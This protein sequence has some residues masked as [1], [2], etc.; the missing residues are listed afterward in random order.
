M[1]ERFSDD[2][3]DVMIAAQ[4][5]ARRLHREEVGTDHLLLAVM[6]KVGRALADLA[7]GKTP[8]LTRARAAA[9]TG[10]AVQNGRPIPYDSDAWRV[11]EDASRLARLADAQ[12]EPGHFLQALL[13][14]QQETDA[15]R[16]L[17]ALHIDQVALTQ[18]CVHSLAERSDAA[19]SSTTDGPAEDRRVDNPLVAP[20]WPRRIL[21]IYR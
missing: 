12:T 21:E 18:W 1:F 7:P 9:M 5:E 3:A 14:Q 19:A 16:L 11:I 20:F 6:M 10:S 17:T 13:R 2:A 15:K 8:L 4:V